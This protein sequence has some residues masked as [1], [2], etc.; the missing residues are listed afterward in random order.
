MVLMKQSPWLLMLLLIAK[1]LVLSTRVNLY[2]IQTF[3][4]RLYKHS[5]LF[6]KFYKFNIKYLEIT[7]IYNYLITKLIA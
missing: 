5:R 3:I 6:C 2:D 7:L 4:N 1:S